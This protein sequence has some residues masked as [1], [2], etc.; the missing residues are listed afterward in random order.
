M[1]VCTEAHAR[2]RSIA[3]SLIDPF[4]RYDTFFVFAARGR[5]VE[6]NENFR[7]EGVKPRR[8]P[9]VWGTQDTL[10][11]VLHNLWACSSP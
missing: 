3:L 8:Y 2:P 7:G 1:S 6:G 10:G 5:L 11:R 9:M 4:R